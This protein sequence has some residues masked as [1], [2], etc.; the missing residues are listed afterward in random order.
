MKRRML[1]LLLALVLCVA[2]V[3][4]KKD[5]KKAPTREPLPVTGKLNVAVLQ[6]GKADAIV[7]TTENKTMVIDTGETDDGGKVLNY[8]TDLG[9]TSVDHLIITH[10]DRDHVGGASRILNFME[11]KQVIRPDYV[12]ERDEYQTLLDDMAALETPDT[13]LPAGSDDMVFMVDDVEVT[14]DVPQKTMYTNNDGLQQDNDFS[15]VVTLRHGAKVFLLAGDCEDARLAELV[16]AKKDWRA[17]FLKLPYHGNYTQL[18]ASFLTKVHPLYAV[19]CDSAK[20]PMAAETVSILQSMEATVY[21]TKDGTVVCQSDGTN[22]VVTQQP[23]S[24]K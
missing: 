24:G 18:T 21:G 12:G 15:L 23:D 22:L 2:L 16:T 11:V 13:V 4:C 20:N 3:G 19:A 8:L 14:I 5:D 17:D 1:A 9:V 7:V 6:I 10:Y